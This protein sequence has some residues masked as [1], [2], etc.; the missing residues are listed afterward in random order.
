MDSG[1]YAFLASGPKHMLAKTGAGSSP[2]TIEI[3]WANEE[4]RRCITACLV[5]GTYG[6]ESDRAMGREDTT[7]ALAP[8]WWE[9]FYFRRLPDYKL[10]CPCKCVFCKTTRHILGDRGAWFIY[11]A[12]FQYAPPDGACRDPS[13]APSYVVAFRGTMI[14]DPTVVHDMRQNLMILLNK[15][16]L[17]TRF[18]HARQMVERLLKEKITN[19]RD[20]DVWLAG[21]S[22]GAA[23]ALDVGRHMMSSSSSSSNRGLIKDLPTF[24]F[25]P[26]HVSL[27]P[28][29][30]E[31]A[32]PHL[33]AVSYITKHTLGKVLT[34]H[35]N[36]MEEL[37]KNLSPWKPNLYVNPCDDLCVGFI[38]YF[39][40]RELMK[41]RFPGLATSAAM[42][43]H[44]DMFHSLFGNECERQHLLPSATL[45]KNS[46]TRS[47]PHRRA[48][49][50]ELRQ[51]WQPKG[52]EL[53][54]TRKEYTWP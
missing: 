8:A 40:Q 10:E 6:L 47:G 17:C 49:A 36:H 15:Q 34:P 20:G 37:F 42:L 52:P 5:K 23:I 45:W 1:D 4:H 38:D 28:A 33:Y 16:H 22:L 54:L 48:R 27:A 30:A 32:K 46:S 31:D 53:D 21:H 19:G 7:Q 18:S 3:D 41:K 35:R 14:G 26:P 2:P 44:R 24:L 11:G 29:I 51:W 50:H 25:N 13:S 12:V 9:S 39:E 43:S